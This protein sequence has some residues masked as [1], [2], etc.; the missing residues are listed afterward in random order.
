MPGPDHS[1][2]VGDLAPDVTDYVLQ[3]SFRQYFPSVRSAKVITDPL[4][5]RSKGYG[6]VRF[7]IEAER[8]RALGEMMGHLISNRPIRVSIATAKKTPPGGPSSNPASAVAPH[9]SD[10]DPSNTTLF[11]G[12]LSANVTED[13]L[14]NLFGRFGDIIYVKVPPG[15]GCGFVQYVHR[16]VA[17]LAMATMQ[18]QVLGGAAI[19]ISWGRSSAARG[20]SSA[21]AAA[22]VGGAGYS[23]FP[24]AQSPYTSS[25]F[26]GYDSQ[27][28]YGGYGTAA[29]AA[30]DPYASAYASYA[31]QQQPRQQTD[32]SALQQAFHSSPYGASAG[33]AGAGAS[34]LLGHASSG[35]G[36][37]G[38]GS[39]PFINA[40]AGKHS[41]V[42]D[43]LASPDI[44]KLN[45]AFI[46]RHI[47]S[48]LGT[49]M[50]S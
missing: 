38:G 7:G 6:F 18:S 3:E 28:S 14:Q 39:A 8:D 5:G 19:R 29:N 17:E 40:L 16:P 47:G 13:D 33:G 45:A 9:P 44:E 10:F 49:H 36:A 4:T 12:G 41:E 26:P 25:A 42:S 20:G 30:A 11:I 22:A 32:T 2:F 37:L 27:A 24:A 35:F 34:P 46:Q 43:P 15:K 1:V 31:A 23:P 50:Y 48:I 21:S